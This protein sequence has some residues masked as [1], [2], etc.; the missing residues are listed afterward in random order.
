MRE[1]ICK[2]MEILRLEKSIRLEIIK[3]IICHQ[4]SKCGEQMERNGQKDRSLEQYE[5][6]IVKTDFRFE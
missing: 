3:K 1:C 5:I 6:K 2:S 4:K